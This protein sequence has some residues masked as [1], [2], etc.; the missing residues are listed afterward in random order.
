MLD[1]ILIQHAET[2]I[3]LLEYRQEETKFK[4]EHSDI[5]SGFLSAIQNITK[6][7][8]IGTVVLISTRGTRGHNCIIIPKPT[9]YV[10]LLVDY[11]DP[12][13][14]WREQGDLIASKFIEKFTDKFDPH[15]IGQFKI[16]IPELKKMCSSN[17]FCD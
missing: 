3:N 9:I 10:I 7:L 8:D 17:P 2:G 5:F 12:I 14:L 4:S 13:D 11:S 1:I 16:F 6:E 15:N